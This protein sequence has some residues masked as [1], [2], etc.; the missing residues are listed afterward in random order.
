MQVFVPKSFRN[1]WAKAM[2]GRSRT[3]A[4]KVMC[5]RCVG[6]ERK[7]VR[8]CTAKETCPLWPYRP[9]QNNYDEEE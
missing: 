8:Y 2:S 4:I 7:E 3:A 5:G 6:W 1:T 9:Y